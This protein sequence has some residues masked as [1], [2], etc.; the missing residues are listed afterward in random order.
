[1][2]ATTARSAPQSMCQAEDQGPPHT[3]FTAASFAV[4]FSNA[5]SNSESVWMGAGVT[6]NDERGVI[7]DTAMAATAIAI[8]G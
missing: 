1:M 7:A 6:V 5:D 8:R 4:T 3:F 2:L